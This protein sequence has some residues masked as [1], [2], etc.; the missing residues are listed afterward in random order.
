MAQ[1]AMRTAAAVAANQRPE[2]S[3]VCA[4]DGSERT[5]KVLTLQFARQPGSR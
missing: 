1:I 5:R 3:A 2:I 4:S